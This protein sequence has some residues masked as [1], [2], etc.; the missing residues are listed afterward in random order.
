MSEVK[1]EKGSPEWD[2]DEERV[3]IDQVPDLGDKTGEELLTHL[4]QAI[5]RCREFIAQ[6]YRLVEFW[7]D[8]DQGIQFIL[9]KRTASKKP[10]G[11]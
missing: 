9:K 10:R 1:L 5:A 3:I 7:S 6:G 8:V 4:E 2:Y 11:D